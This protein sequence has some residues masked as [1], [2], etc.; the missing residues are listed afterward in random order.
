MSLTP[1]SLPPIAKI[2]GLSPVNGYEH[3]EAEHDKAEHD[4]P[5]RDKSHH[6]AIRTRRRGRARVASRRDGPGPIV[7]PATR[8]RRAIAAS[9]SAQRL[10]SPLSRQP[11]RQVPDRPRRGP[12]GVPR[13]GPPLHPPGVG[14]SGT[15]GRPVRLAGD[16]PDHRE[17]DGARAGHRVPHQLQGNQHGPHRAAVRHAALG[18]GGRAPRAAITGWARPPGRKGRGSRSSTTPSSSPSSTVSWPPSRRATTA[19]RGCATST[20]AASATGAKAT[21]GPAAA[22]NAASR[23]ASSTSIC[24][25]STFNA[26]SS[27][28]P[29]TSSMP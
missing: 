10:V 24:T 25:S 19:S 13:H 11:H 5:E 21:P 8:R 23:R 27:S 9:Q 22:R 6:R 20:S 12:A 4:K 28:S 26:R 29:T 2:G 17:V 3:H 1:M 7:R 15:E 16:R 18:D 14:L